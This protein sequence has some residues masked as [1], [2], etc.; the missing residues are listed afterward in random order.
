MD[1]L[2]AEDNRSSSTP[3][4]ARKPFNESQKV[5]QRKKVSSLRNLVSQVW[6]RSSVSRRYPPLLIT[7]PRSGL[8]KKRSSVRP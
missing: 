2:S 7:K 3:M 5:R 6:P 4:V 8:K 1:I